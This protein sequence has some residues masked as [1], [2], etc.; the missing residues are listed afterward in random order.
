MGAC[1]WEELKEELLPQSSKEN[2]IFFQAELVSFLGSLYRPWIC[3]E[4]GEEKKK[5]IQPQHIFP[6]NAIF[7][8]Q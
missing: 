3:F 5:R 6:N 4:E 2:G 7:L 1:Y 8:S